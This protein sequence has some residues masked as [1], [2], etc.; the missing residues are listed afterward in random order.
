[1]TET[2]RVSNIDGR[3]VTIACAGKGTCKSCSSSFCATDQRIFEASNTKGFNINVGDTVDVYLAPGKT[4]AAG[5]LVLIVPLILFMV[6]Y[7]VSGRLFSATSEG[8]QALFGLVGLAAGFGLSFL[9]G[10]K[11]R[12]SNMPEII[13]VREGNASAFSD[14]DSSQDG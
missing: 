14:G 1:M 3:T 12:A 7:S 5:F 4:V 9:Y 2:A 8:I 13:R 6:G 11:K 10:K